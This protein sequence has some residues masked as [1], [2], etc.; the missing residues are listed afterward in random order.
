MATNRN[1][2]ATVTHTL[3]SAVADDATFTVSYP[4]GYAQTD[5]NVG[6]AGT[7]HKMIVNDNDVWTTADPGF[8]VAFGASNITITNTT[9]ASLAAG[10]TILLQF[11]LVDGND[12]VIFGFPIDLASVTAADVV[13]EFRPGVDGV[14]E[15]FSFVV[16]KAVT[17]AAKAATLNLE[18]GTTNVTGGTIALTSAAATPKGKVIECAAITGANTI[19]RADTLSIE[20]ASVTAF[21][22]GTGT[23]YVRI[24]RT[25]SD[26]Y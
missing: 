25:R 14:I 17:T 6:L 18:I 11:D 4:S 1:L 7:G 16:D 21:S 12:V 26:N 23:A 10:S 2:F 15:N 22:E 13:T 8:T 20:A 3:A 24:R 5:F 19:T 9:G